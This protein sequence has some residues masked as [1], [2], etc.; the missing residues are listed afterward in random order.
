LFILA[1]IKVRVFCAW[2]K[3]AIVNVRATPSSSD[4]IIII[5]T[6]IEGWKTSLGI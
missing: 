6:C 5:V 2:N 4:S 3:F 1:G